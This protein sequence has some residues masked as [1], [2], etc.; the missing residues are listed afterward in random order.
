MLRV[1]I[2]TFGKVGQLD[3]APCAFA[4][5]EYLDEQ[6]DPAGIETIDARQVKDELCLAMIG[7]IVEGLAQRLN[8]RP[9]NETSLRSD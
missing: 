7:E 9:E 1:C 5:L 4:G 8:R 3:V 2:T 6:A